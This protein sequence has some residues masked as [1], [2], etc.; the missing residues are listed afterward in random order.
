VVRDFDFSTPF[1]LVDD[2]H[3]IQGVCGTDLHIHD[4]EFMVKFPV[5]PGH[6]VVGCIAK[7]GSKV[8][9]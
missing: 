9:K 3:E 4:G 2:D 8:T 6:E 5:I 7:L 1:Q